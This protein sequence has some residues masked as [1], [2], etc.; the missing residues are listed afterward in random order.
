MRTSAMA[1]CGALLVWAGAARAEC[2]LAPLRQA[3]QAR[4]STGRSRRT[5]TLSRQVRNARR[6][7]APGR[8]IASPCCMWPTR[9]NGTNRGSRRSRC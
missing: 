9:S 2:P 3:V 7:S 1:L 6:R 5:P 8:V 4:D